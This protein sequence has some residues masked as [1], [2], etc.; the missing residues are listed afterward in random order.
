VAVD[1]ERPV[2][3]DAYLE[4][5][6]LDVDAVTDGTEVL[7]PGLIEHVEHA[8]VHSGDSI[9]IYPPQRVSAVD[10][11]L[12]VD[13]ITRIAL[14]IGVRGLINGQFIVR[15]DGVYLLE[16]NPRASRTVPFLSK[17]T[18]VP[19]VELA[20]RVALGERL[21]DLG[22]SGGLLTPRSLVAV[23]APVFSTHKLRG[24]DPIVG[25]AMQSTGEVIGIHHDPNVA[26]A[27]ALVAASLRPPTPDPE[28]GSPI[29]L[30]SIAD[31]DKDAVA[32][33]A[34]RTVA[35]GY[36][37]AAT[38]GTAVALRVAGH[39]VEL[40]TRVGEAD[41]SGRSV[42]DAISSGDVLLVVNTPSPESR[43]VED[44]G[45]IRRAALAEGILCL[46]SIDTALAATAALD[47]GLAEE[48]HDV[49]SLDE[50]LVGGGAP[51]ST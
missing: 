44:A 40:V 32:E 43:P 51:I 42:L 41:G 50:W 20:T 9:G 11:Q 8:G 4:G 33:L 12:V 16:V 13:A 45:A 22:W 47:P 39:D 34:Q 1:D 3:I 19:M 31:R 46:T 7:I 6:E 26:M 23:K 36:R 38:R 21:A 25:P 5:L 14:A 29:A 15:D 48:I 30:L 49:R 18:G 24:V 37:L 35:A 17:V 2:R 27:K 28:R 10:Q